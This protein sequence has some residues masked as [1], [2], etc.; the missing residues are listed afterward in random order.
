MYSQMLILKEYWHREI[1]DEN[2][3]NKAT[4]CKLTTSHIRWSCITFHWKH[5]DNLCISGF[6]E[7][8]IRIRCQK[9]SHY[10]FI[11][12]SSL[13]L[14]LPWSPILK[15]KAVICQLSMNACD[16]THT[17]G[18]SGKGDVLSCNFYT[19]LLYFCWKIH[20]ICFW[21]LCVKIGS[22]FC[23]LT[24]ERCLKARWG[25]RNDSEM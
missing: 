9:A 17:Q 2:F 21:E 15:L 5:R 19:F 24:A 1:I 8:S 6:Q 20:L 3:F 25:N 12:I 18:S 11:I 7:A 4:E 13:H 10:C 16:R 22:R 23:L 14:F